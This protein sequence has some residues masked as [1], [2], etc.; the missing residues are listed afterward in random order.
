MWYHIKTCAAKR[1]VAMG[2]AWEC[3][4]TY[5]LPGLGNLPE[6]P[7]ACDEGE[8][9]DD[10]QVL[11]SGKHVLCVEDKR[12]A[13]HITLQSSTVPSNKG[14]YCKCHFTSLSQAKQEIRLRTSPQ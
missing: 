7:V 11:E 13:R 1:G 4:G 2:G 14:D 3:I 5:S 9:T 12:A 8:A 6:H 10:H